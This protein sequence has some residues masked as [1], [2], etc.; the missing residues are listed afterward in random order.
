M[1]LKLT[2]LSPFPHSFFMTTITRIK[3]ISV[4]LILVFFATNAQSQS[5]PTNEST[6]I[7]PKKERT[8]LPFNVKQPAAPE[9][10]PKKEEAGK[11]LEKVEEKG[12]VTAPVT[13]A[14]PPPPAPATAGK[15][16]TPAEKEAHVKL[17]QQIIGQAIKQCQS[18]NQIFRDLS[19]EETRTSEIMQGDKIKQKK[20]VVTEMVV[21]QS[22]FTPQIAYEFRN[23]KIVNDKELKVDEK[24]L[25]KLFK[26]LT[27]VKEPSQELEI[28]NDEGFQHDLEVGGH[29]YGLTLFQWREMMDW[30]LPDVGFEL[31]GR[32]KIDGKDVIA[33][34]FDQQRTNKNLE[35]QLPKNAGLSKHA[36][37]TMGILYFD[38]STLQIRRA[39][40]ELHLLAPGEKKYFRIWKQTLNFKPSTYGILVP[41]EFVAE[42]FYNF[43]REKDGSITTARTGRLTSSFGEFKQFN[44]TSEE[45]KNKKVVK[46]LDSPQ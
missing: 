9:P 29:F 45:E 1:L 41:S 21:Y 3:F 35:W 10:E 39:I 13:A 19:A 14:P 28:L 30:A 6:T 46:P 20:V 37:K 22:R 5:S 44:V 4:L 16:M 7:P 38:P 34:Y 17:L 32:E 18:Y 24:H 23:A 2:L 43:S 33:V 26:K 12:I 27:T 40:R 31:I 11:V 8:L 15:E 25:E 42:Y 36:Q